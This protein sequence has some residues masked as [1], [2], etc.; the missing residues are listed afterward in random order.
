[1]TEN[2]KAIDLLNR[3]GYAGEIDADSAGKVV[4]LCGWV[5]RRRDHGGVI[6]IDLRDRAGLAQIVFDP[7]HDQN[8][9]AQAEALRSEFVVGIRG[10]V[11]MRP[12]GMQNPNLPTGQVEVLVDELIVFSESD[13]PPFALDANTSEDAAEEGR[14]GSHVNENT[15]L[16]YRYL[17]LRRPEL[18]QNF[19]IRHQV[20]GLIRKTLNDMAF[21]DV[22]T[23]YLTKSTPEGARDFLVPSRIHQGSFYA[24]PQ[25]PQLFKQLLMISGMDRYYQIVRCFRDE[26]LRADRQ[27]EFTQLDLEMSFVTR[28]KIFHV[29]ERVFSVLFSEI[30]HESIPHELPRISHSDAMRDYG[31]D[32]P[33]RR[34]E[35]K[36]KNLDSVF[37]NTQFKVFQNILA[38]GGTIRGLSFPINEH[39]PQSRTQLD[40]LKDI[41][42]PFGFQGL[43]WAKHEQ[44]AFRSSIEKFLSDEEK[45]GLTEAFQLKNDHIG[46]MIAGPRTKALPALGALRLHLIDTLQLKPNKPYDLH[47][48]TD[49][50]LFDATDQGGITSS[51]HPFTAPVPEDWDKVATD[52]LSVNSQAYDLVM[53]GTELGSGSIRIHDAKLQKQIFEVL[54]I[55]AEEIEQRFG[56]FL[57]AM[58]Y[59][60]P[61]HGGIA[62]GVD[63]LAALFVGKNSIRD[64][65]AFPK[66][67]KG[68]CLTTDAP[69][70]V[71]VDQLLELHLSQIKAQPK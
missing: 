50:P 36:L 23:P 38:D 65:I 60:A 3:T 29:I 27:P 64:V 56:F 6:F 34:F 47:W 24:L 25:S 10:T 51:H 66:T 55:D 71:K 28:E 14:E 68:S 62:I 54:K 15:R 12:D 11:R 17:D 37:A 42:E 59:G 43:V 33:D 22:E 45:A 5:H 48:V 57:N 69:S 18:Q 32:K 41:V 61:P 52:P 7:A 20:V 21:L 44:Q 63:R 35:L 49:F 40:R 26:D 67:Q 9:H 13:T 2:N 39:A 31:T 70:P 16:R 46:V 53:N 19:K 1:M 58:R 30:L 4:T 8:V